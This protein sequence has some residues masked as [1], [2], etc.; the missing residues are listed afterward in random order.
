MNYS[1]E[2][3]IEVAALSGPNPGF[4][5]PLTRTTRRPS[6]T[7]IMT[8]PDDLHPDIRTKRRPSHGTHVHPFN[9]KTRRRRESSPLGRLENSTVPALGPHLG[10]GSALSLVVDAE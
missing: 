4:G 2:D 7:R 8:L 3:N 5:S 1:G 6:P 10:E 9:L